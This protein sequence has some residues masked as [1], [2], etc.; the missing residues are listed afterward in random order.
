MGFSNSISPPNG[1]FP[2]FCLAL[3]RAGI[4]SRARFV[5]LC[6][7]HRTHRARDGKL[8]AHG[9]HCRA[10]PRDPELEYMPDGRVETLDYPRRGRKRSGPGRI[11]D[12][13]GNA[14]F[15]LRQPCQSTRSFISF[16]Y[17]FGYEFVIDFHFRYCYTNATNERNLRRAQA[18]S[19]GYR[20]TRAARR[21]R[22]PRLMLS[23]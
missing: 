10:N 14:R 11:T 3:S 17:E 23:Y 19:H 5:E 21:V 8:E 1:R 18:P 13:A 20:I 2:F 7:K 4:N 9:R 22:A 15:G 16:R 6:R 12:G